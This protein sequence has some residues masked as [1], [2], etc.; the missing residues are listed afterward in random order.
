MR[1][2]TKNFKKIEGVDLAFVCWSSKTTAKGSF[3]MTCRNILCHAVLKKSAGFDCYTALER[4]LKSF[5]QLQCATVLTDCK[6]L[7]ALATRTA[8]PSRVVGR[9]ER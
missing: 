7:F 3:H 1:A 8:M 4:S 2:T 6:S 9:N 5:L